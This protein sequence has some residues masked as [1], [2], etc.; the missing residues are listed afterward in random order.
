MTGLAGTDDPAAPDPV[1]APLR[2]S[3]REVSSESIREDMVVTAREE[4]GVSLRLR[5]GSIKIGDALR[6]LIRDWS[7]GRR[8]WGV[9]AT[10]AGGEEPAARRTRGGEGPGTYST[11]L[12]LPS[13]FSSS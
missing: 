11:S 1:I 12:L 10:S 9:S 2:I 13:N 6:S 8:E 4:E 5:T 7:G 3:D